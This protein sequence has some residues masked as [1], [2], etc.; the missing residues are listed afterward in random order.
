[1]G[2]RLISFKYSTFSSGTRC[3]WVDASLATAY[4]AIRYGRNGEEDIRGWEAAGD[5]WRGI[6]LP[7]GD[8]VPQILKTDTDRG[9]N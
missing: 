2:E 7:N 1:M 8:V 3:A 9:M 4:M 6:R 5:A